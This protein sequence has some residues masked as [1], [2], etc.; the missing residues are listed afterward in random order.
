MQKTVWNV[1][2]TLVIDKWNLALIPTVLNL[3]IKNLLTYVKTKYIL[4]YNRSAQS[5]VFWSNDFRWFN[6][7]RH[8]RQLI[9][10]PNIM[11]NKMRLSLRK[12]RNLQFCSVD[13]KLWLNILTVLIKN[14]SKLVYQ[15]CENFNAN[16]GYH[17]NW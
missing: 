3:V 8:W 6:F 12:R 1:V 14:E 9:N 17:Q 2:K 5:M 16:F 4:L 10:D 13:V 11:V 15:N 7:H